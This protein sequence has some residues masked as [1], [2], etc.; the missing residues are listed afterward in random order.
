M[1]GGDAMRW[2]RQ[3]RGLVLGSVLVAAMAAGGQGQ[4]ARPTALPLE[5]ALAKARCQGKYAMLLRQF[6]AEADAAQYGAF[7]DLGL[8]DVKEHQ[9]Q[10]DLPKGH[11]V[12]VYPYWYVWRDLAAETKPKRNWGPE[13]IIGEPDAPEGG[14]S[15]NAWASL[16]ADGQDEWLLLEYARPVT[17]KAVHVYENYYPGAV[18]RVTAFRLD[19]TEVELWRGKDPTPQEEDKGVSVIPVKADF[20]TNRLKVYLDSRNVPNWNEVDAVGLHDTDGKVHWV[21]AA[22]ASSTYARE[23]TPPVPAADP[24]QVMERLTKVEN[25]VREVKEM[26]KE[27]RELLRDL[28]KDRK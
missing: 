13:Q 15:V 24:T 28:K 10:T 25:E 6:K 17:P 26:V 14:D 11:W 9:G 21:T 4:E 7:K 2:D 23:A 22:E 1:S 16:T 5:E 3:N 12:Y 20:K 8:R 27:I 18:V 19:G